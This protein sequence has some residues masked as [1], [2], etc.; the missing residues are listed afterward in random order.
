M[1]FVPVECFIRLGLVLYSVMITE[2]PHITSGV[3]VLRLEQ[4]KFYVGAST[5]IQARVQN[6]DSVWTRKYEPIMVDDVFPA[7]EDIKDLEREVT[8]MYMRRHGW[9]NVR[10]AGW[11]RA[12]MESKPKP[13][14]EPA[15]A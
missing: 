9:E 10:G 2:H 13:L 15:V 1:Q 5:N 3:Y 4:G 7:K 11:T 14:R 6:H 8:L 12:E